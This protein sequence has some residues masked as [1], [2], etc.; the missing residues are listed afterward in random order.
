MKGYKWNKFSE[1]QPTCTGIYV[2]ISHSKPED[3]YLDDY[4]ST[5]NRKIILESNDEKSI[6]WA[7]WKY[8]EICDEIT[9]EHVIYKKEWGFFDFED[10]QIDDVIYYLSLP[11][12][13][14]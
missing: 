3:I 4:S 10:N 5:R 7:R 12:Y 11:N 2:V 14:K 8:R 9:N 13:P 1:K 6:R